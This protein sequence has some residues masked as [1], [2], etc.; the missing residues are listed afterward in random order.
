MIDDNKNNGSNTEFASSVKQRAEEKAAEYH[1]LLHEQQRIEMLLE[2]IRKYIDKLNSVL[3][4][5]GQS[6]IVLREPKSGS[7]V[8]K[9]GNRAKDFPIRKVQ[10]EGM[11]LFDIVHSILNASPTQILHAD[12]IAHQVYEIQNKKDLQRV[13][14]SLVSTLRRGAKDGRWDFVPRNKYKAKSAIA[15]ERLIKV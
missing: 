11:T 7:I 14:R 10:W 3:E 15:Q 6:P 9:P 4:A 5:E 8:A 2:R 12:V 13:K 1:N